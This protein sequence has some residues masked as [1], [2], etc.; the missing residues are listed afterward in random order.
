MNTQNVKQII[1]ELARQNFALYPESYPLENSLSTNEA[2]INA[3][4]LAIAYWDNRLETEEERDEALNI[5]KIDYVNW[6][7]EEY[8]TFVQN[9]LADNE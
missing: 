4:E 3:Q 2:T 9:Q 5:S 1:Q 8:E 6:V 7:M